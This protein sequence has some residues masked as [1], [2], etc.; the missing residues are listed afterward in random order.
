M[1]QTLDQPQ[2]RTPSPPTLGQ[3]A[4]VEAAFLVIGVVITLL[5]ARRPLSSLLFVRVDP[6]TELGLG[7]VVGISL[8]VVTASVILSS[9]IRTRV[10]P[11]LDNFSGIEPTLLSF[12]TLGLLAGLGE[13][14][15]FRA[16]LQPLLGIVLASLLFTL[17]HA[18][19]AQFE[20][21]TAGKLGYALFAFGMGLV[22]GVLYGQAGIVA[23]VV[24]HASF[25]TT[26][27]LMI[28]PLVPSWTERRA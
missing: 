7:L 26:F 4:I 10:P 24:A 9:P 20:K 21:P 3:T 1:A 13:E 2:G 23:A 5:I 19:I 16:T 25:D 14:T 22:L 6:L 18:P 28:R 15:L 17:A 11:F 8:S 12:V 27:Y